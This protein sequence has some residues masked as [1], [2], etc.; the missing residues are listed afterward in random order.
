M[1]VFRD[2]DLSFFTVVHR[3]NSC[4]SLSVANVLAVAPLVLTWTAG[5]AACVFDI[6]ERVKLFVEFFE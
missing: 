1:F 5:T 3:V 2:L 4:V 6:C